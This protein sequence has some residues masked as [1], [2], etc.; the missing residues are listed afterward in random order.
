MFNIKFNKENYFEGNPGSSNAEADAKGWTS[1]W[2]TS[3]PQKNQSLSL[4]TSPTV[5]TNSGRSGTSQH[6]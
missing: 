6:G 5:T 1:L 4:E 3:I 2:K